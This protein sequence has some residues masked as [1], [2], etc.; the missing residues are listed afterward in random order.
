MR[1]E[2][3]PM[4]LF[5]VIAQMSVGAFWVLGAVH[6]FAHLRGTRPQTVDRVSTAAMFAVG[7]LLVLGFVAAFFHLGDPFHALNTLR[8]LGSSWLSRELAGGTAFGTLGMAFAAC[9]WFGL[10]SRRLRAVLAALTAAAMSPAASKPWRVSW[11]TR[12]DS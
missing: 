1:T 11:V 10:L 5:T 3:L 8:H 6:L 2:E 12:Q 4:I 7:P 9:E